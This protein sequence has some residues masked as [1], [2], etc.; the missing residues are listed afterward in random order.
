MKSNF[1]KIFLYIMSFFFKELNYVNSEDII[2]SG[3]YKFFTQFIKSKLQGRKGIYALMPSSS[4]IIESK[5]IY[6][7]MRILSFS[8]T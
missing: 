8:I 2:S 1:R 4:T 6:I 7:T 3:K 5:N